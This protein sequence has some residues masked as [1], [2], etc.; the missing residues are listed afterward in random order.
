MDQLEKLNCHVVEILEEDLELFHTPQP[1]PQMISIVVEWLPTIRPAQNHLNSAAYL[2]IDF[3]HRHF[4]PQI[5]STEIHRF[6]GILPRSA[7]ATFLVA[8]APTRRAHNPSSFNSKSSDTSATANLAP[9]GP[10]PAPATGLAGARNMPAA[11]N[12]TSIVTYVGVALTPLP[13]VPHP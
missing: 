4:L 3:N 13:A 5:I 9:S 10:G 7:R 6:V 11:V 2:V 12:S 8:P 1:L